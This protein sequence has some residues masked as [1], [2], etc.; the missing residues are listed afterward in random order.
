MY[1]YCIY[2]QL[3]ARTFNQRGQTIRILD[4]QRLHR[5]RKGRRKT[6]TVLN[7]AELG[8]RFKVDEDQLKQA[9]IAAGWDYHEDANGQLWA[10]SQDD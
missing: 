5:Q 3:T 2:I 1:K 4:T 7:H 9:L 8:E 6:V 10:V